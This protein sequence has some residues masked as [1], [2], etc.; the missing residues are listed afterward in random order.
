MGKHTFSPNLV[1]F[2][3]SV[4]LASLLYGTKFRVHSCVAK[5]LDLMSKVGTHTSKCCKTSINVGGFS[6]PN[7]NE[8]ESN[9]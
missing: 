7:S 4:D 5:V 2:L 3:A 8:M 9:F 1:S 6:T